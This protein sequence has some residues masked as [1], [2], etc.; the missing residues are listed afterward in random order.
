M[1][2]CIIGQQDGHA[3]KCVLGPPTPG[4]RHFHNRHAEEVVI[5]LALINKYVFIGRAKPRAS[6]PHAGFTKVWIYRKR[7]SPAIVVPQ[8]AIDGRQKLTILHCVQP[9]LELT[10]SCR[11]IFMLCRAACFRMAGK[12][13]CG[14]VPLVPGVG[15]IQRL[16][17]LRLILRSLA[18]FVTPPRRRIVE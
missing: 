7:C 18:V 2:I 14:I 3:L 5:L 11:L 9:Y 10:R 17:E 4:I 1:D 13:R 12:W 8:L 16:T 6:C 15:T